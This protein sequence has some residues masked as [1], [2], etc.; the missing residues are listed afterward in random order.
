MATIRYMRLSFT[1]KNRIFRVQDRILFGNCRIYLEPGIAEFSYLLSKLLHTELPK[2]TVSLCL[3]RELCWVAGSP[4]WDSKV[5]TRRYG[6]SVVLLGNVDC[7]QLDCCWEIYSCKCFEGTT[8]LWQKGWPISLYI[9]QS[10]LRGQ[11]VA[12]G[13]ARYLRHSMWRLLA[14]VTWQ[15][16][17]SH[18]YAISLWNNKARQHLYWTDFLWYSELKTILNLPLSPHM[19]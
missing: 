19:I 8:P 6:Q 5:F 14:L 4:V 10:R 1:S 13:V 18:E 15:R 7:W 12:I 3:F 9:F 16:Q 2:Y 11:I 17:I